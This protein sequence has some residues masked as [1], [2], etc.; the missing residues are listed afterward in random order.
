MLTALSSPLPEPDA[1]ARAHSAVVLAEVRAAIASAGGFI[2]FEQYMQRVLYAPGLGYYVAGARKF[3]ADGDFVTAPEMTPLFGGALATQVAAILALTRGRQVVELGAGS[4]VLAADLLN[5][6]AGREALPAHYVIL[7]VSPE[8]RERQ[9]ATITARAPAHAG[10]VAWIE[11]PPD[12]ID[13]AIVMNEVL[14][15]VPPAIVTRRNGA[16]FERGVTAPAGLAWAERPLR[17]AALLAAAQARFPA[18]IDFMS[19]INLTAEALIRD[20]ARRMT[21]GAMLIVDYGHAQHDYYAP[22][23]DGGT[24]RAHYRHRALDDPF[25][26]PGLTDLTAHVD[27]TAIAVAGCDAGLTLAGYAAQAAFLVNVGILD[28]LQAAGAPTAP[29]FLRE[30]SAVQK[31]LSPT[32][33]GESFKVLALA[34]SEDIVWSGFAHGDRTHKL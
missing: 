7:E 3:G 20:L 25:I 33:M 26:W 34:R 29:A 14:D 5:A 24:L 16:W 17:D 22:H 23:R 1:D 6:L 21:G 9:R 10:H 32:A 4:G 8:L 27:F 18:T 30:A 12:S 28:A 15:A 2:S 19:E 13:G 11:T 31:L